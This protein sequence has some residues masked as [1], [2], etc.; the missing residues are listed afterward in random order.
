L[1]TLG[2]ILYDELVYQRA[3]IFYKVQGEIVLELSLVVLWAASF[4]GMASYVSEMSVLTSTLA[5][6]DSNYGLNDDVL[7]KTQTSQSACIAIAILGS[8]EL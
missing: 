7:T 3:K 6:F 4:A 8:V 1:L 2:V 5:G